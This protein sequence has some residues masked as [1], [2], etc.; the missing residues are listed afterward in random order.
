M[1]IE[2]LEEDFGGV[3]V[4]SGT[5]APGISY[6]GSTKQ[7]TTKYKVDKPK[8]VSLIKSKKENHDNKH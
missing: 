6:G 1:K 8:I 5:G 2:K 3:G 7:L 4:S